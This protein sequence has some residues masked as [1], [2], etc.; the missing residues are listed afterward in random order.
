[1]TAINIRPKVESKGAYYTCRVWTI[2]GKKRP[3]IHLGRK[4]SPEW[5]AKYA[6][7]CEVTEANGGKLPDDLVAEFQPSKATGDKKT[8]KKPA[9]KMAKSQSKTNVAPKTQNVP[10]DGIRLDADT[11][12]RVKINPEVVKEY[13]DLYRAKR[14]LPKVNLVYDGKF[15]Y[16]WDGFHRILGRKEAGFQTIPAEVLPGSVEDAR[17][18]AVSANQTHGLKRTNEDKRRAVEISLRLRPK[19]SDRQIAEHCGVAHPMVGEAR[20]RLEEFTSQRTGRDGRTIDMKNI[21]KRRNQESQ[22]SSKSESKPVSQPQSTPESKPSVDGSEPPA[23][24]DVET[25]KGA[26]AEA[27]PEPQRQPQLQTKLS[28]PTDSPAE[29]LTGEEEQ[30]DILKKQAEDRHRWL[31]ELAGMVDWVEESIVPHTDRELA[32]YTQPGEPGY[33][34]HGVTAGRLEGVIDQLGRVRAVAFQRPVL[35]I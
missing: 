28:E 21:G 19:M 13:A 24:P 22:S 31:D 8:G 12:A 5:E 35:P 34:D 15:F 18:L 9:A 14:T 25:P 27:V 11:Q 17:W 26:P 20:K 29:E 2:P 23:K 16:P 1:M 30:D 3:T 7:L 10:L 33:F 4:D 32:S 6:R